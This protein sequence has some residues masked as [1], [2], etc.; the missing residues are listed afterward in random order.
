MVAEMRTE[1]DGVQGSRALYAPIALFVYN[2]PEHTR[3][4]LS[5]LQACEGFGQ[6]PLYVF[7]DGARNAAAAGKVEAVRQIVHDMVGCHATIVESESNRGLANSIIS[8]VNRLCD[9]YGK[10]IV[11]EDDLM[12]AEGFLTYMNAALNRYEHDASVMQVSGYMF[13][14]PEFRGLDTAMFLPFTTSWGWGVWKRAW[15]CFDEQAAGWE[16]L[17]SDSNLCKAFNLGGA[18]DYC[19]MLHRQMAGEIDSWAIRWYWSVFNHHGHIAYPP[20]SYV[21]NTGF[22]GYGTH[23]GQFART[24]LKDHALASGLPAF[25]GDVQVD[26]EQY[27]LVC[28]FIR[29]LNVRGWK[30]VLGMLA[31]ALRLR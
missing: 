8:G 21:R 27:A 7:C 19:A 29:Q 13:D 31:A 6:S 22:D 5:F 28:R 11:V 26:G 24:I 20:R 15:D 30:K 12:L 23:G 17:R 1:L 25:P 16:R 18:Y 9:E 10:A 3:R 4:V 14:I 2:R